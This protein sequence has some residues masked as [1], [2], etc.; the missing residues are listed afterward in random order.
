MIGFANYAPKHT[1]N[2]SGIQP[3]AKAGPGKP[4]RVT[5]PHTCPSRQQP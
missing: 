5:A 1:L 4:S 3:S 2:G